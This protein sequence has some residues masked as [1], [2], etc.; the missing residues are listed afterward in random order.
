MMYEATML[1]IRRL[2][3]AETTTE[4]VSKQYFLYLRLKAEYRRVLE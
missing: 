3:C 1:A 4:A 2:R